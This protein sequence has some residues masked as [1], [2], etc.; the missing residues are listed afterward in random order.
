MKSKG[1]AVNNLI[2]TSIT[3]LYGFSSN[4]LIIILLSQ[5]FP[6][7]I[8]V[9]YPF[10]TAF[11]LFFLIFA[12]FGL[13]TTIIQKLSASK[14]KKLIVN[15]LISEGFKWELLFT[16]IASLTLFFTAETFEII[17]GMPNLS[18]VLKFTSLY[19]FF[20]NLIHYF[21]SSFQGLW[22]FKLY[23]LSSIIL[24]SIKLIIVLLNS[25]TKF[26]IYI[27]IALFSL[28]ALIHFF[29]IIVLM[30][31]KYKL[32][33]NLFKFDLELAKDL[34][35]FTFYV[36]LPVLLMYLISNF[37]QFILAF[38][39]PPTDLAYYFIAF[40]FIQV[41][42]IPIFIF[43]RLVIPYASHYM[44]KKEEKMKYIPILYNSIF[45]YGLLIVIPISFYIFYFS[46]HLVILIF[47]VEYYQAS[48]YLK[49]Y[50]FYLIFKMIS[51]AGEPFI[52]ASGKPKLVFKI[53]S[54]AAFF[55]IIMSF[56]LIPHYFIYGAIIS[57]IVPHSIAI[58]FSIYLVK[59]ENQIKIE[60]K[61][62]KSILIY[63][64]SSICS[65]L[66]LLLII[67]LF[68]LDLSILIF[69]IILS[70]I[71][72]LMYF[73]PIILSRTITITE[74]KEFIDLVK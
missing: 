69:L 38:Y 7:N 3:E 24:N 32:I 65:L 19:L 63:V 5:M 59:K 51:V 18:L 26:P 68:K 30:Q 36:F 29:F 44:Q 43:I 62:I 60:S 28:T 72:Y 47:G 48:I 20:F 22:N 9:L 61:T 15:K 14:E 49:V 71:Y 58:L 67:A 42:Y 12:N 73:F 23:S 57:I 45:K 33:S 8:F 46:D 2:L 40:M 55:T 66:F 6:P 31:I 21:E 41:L 74:I 27:I 16:M 1:K 37:N 64:L 70:G 10:S 54:L 11:L 34:L 4:I 50:I 39:I 53:N 25:I 56:L 13:N 35:V 52:L 17:Y